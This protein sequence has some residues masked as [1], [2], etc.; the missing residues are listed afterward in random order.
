MLFIQVKIFQ[1]FKKARKNDFQ[2]FFSQEALRFA[3][4]DG[5]V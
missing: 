4:I 3:V 2:F 5:R 1:G